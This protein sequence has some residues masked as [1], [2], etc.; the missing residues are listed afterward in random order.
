[1]KR[2]YEY[3][4]G[5]KNCKIIKTTR[6]ADGLDFGEKCGDITAPSYDG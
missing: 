4:C 5:L 2:I 6:L 3:L 1:M